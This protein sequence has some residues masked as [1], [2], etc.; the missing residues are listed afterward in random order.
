[1]ERVKAPRNVFI[2]FPLGRQCGK[3]HDREL[4]TT[5]VKKAL[6]HLKTAQTPGEF[7]DLPFDWD[8]P[9]DWGGYLKDVEQMLKSEKA[10]AQAWEPE[11]RKTEAGDRKS[12]V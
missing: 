1:M 5:I 9:F 10:D 6:A 8:A 11:P 4:Q 7:L 2:N 12:D 3:P